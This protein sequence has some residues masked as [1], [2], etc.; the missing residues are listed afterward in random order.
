MSALGTYARLSADQLDEVLTNVNVSTEEKQLAL[1]YIAKYL[2][3]LLKLINEKGGI[4]LFQNL[5]S[6]SC[7]EQ[8][9]IAA[10]ESLKLTPTQMCRLQTSTSSDG[11]L[12][13][14]SEKIQDG[15]LT[16]IY[17]KFENG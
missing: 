4:I 2:H 1:F 16:E 13:D 15:E 11:T 12:L 3:Y 17:E 10:K 9:N 7:L 14:F 6:E 5:D 8:I